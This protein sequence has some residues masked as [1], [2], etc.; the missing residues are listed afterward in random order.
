M[1]KQIVNRQ[2]AILLPNYPRHIYLY[3]L[4]EGY[5]PDA[6]LG[7]LDLTADDLQNER[8]RL[9]VEQHERFILRALEITNDPHLSLRLSKRL[10]PNTA[11]IV[12]LAA[13]NSGKISSALHLIMRYNKVFTRTLSIEQVGSEPVLQIDSLL[14]NE[15]VSYFAVSVMMLSINN[16]VS[17]GANSGSLVRRAEMNMKK[18]PGFNAVHAEFGFPMTFGH[19]SSRLYLNEAPLDTPLPQ[20]DPATV[21]MLM[22]MS[23][24]Q[25]ASANQEASVIGEVTALLAGLV[26]APPKLDEAAKL[27]GYSPRNLRRR[28]QEAGTTYQKVLDSIRQ[29]MAEQLLQETDESVQNIAYELGFESPSHFGRAFKRWTG[30]APSEARNI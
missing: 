17:Y 3:L 15:L 24:K 25:L 7:G 12:I 28:L 16:L 2:E 21:R 14:D 6:L 18:P 1:S 13:L 19:K 27:L 20:A 22:E 29:R 4:E 23:E 9:S 11:G 8:F 30:R 26:S 5:E 10:N